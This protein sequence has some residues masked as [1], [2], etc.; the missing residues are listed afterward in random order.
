MDVKGRKP[1]KGNNREKKRLK[2]R[3]RK[4]SMKSEDERQYREEKG[5]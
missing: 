4:K 2:G 5:E 3:K 1:R